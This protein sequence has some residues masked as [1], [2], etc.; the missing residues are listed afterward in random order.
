MQGTEGRREWTTGK[1]DVHQGSRVPWMT[2]MHEGVAVKDPP[3]SQGT[4]RL[5]HSDPEGRYPKNQNGKLCC[6][7]VVGQW[8]NFGGGALHKRWLVTVTYNCPLLS[9]SC[10]FLLLCSRTFVSIRLGVGK[11]SAVLGFRVE[12][13]PL[14]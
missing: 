8:A 11:K 4:R 9:L 3:S 14:L 13:T 10:D 1:R 5:F 7:A 2:R 6:V 12:E